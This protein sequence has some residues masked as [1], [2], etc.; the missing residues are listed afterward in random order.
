MVEI[1]KELIEQELAKLRPVMEKS[2]L[3]ERMLWMAWHFL[4][5]G[6]IG[7][8]EIALTGPQKDEILADYLAYKAQLKTDASNL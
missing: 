8:L 2:K 7:Y 4:D 1:N 3:L 5:S 6:R